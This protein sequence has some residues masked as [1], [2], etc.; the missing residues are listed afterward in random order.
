MYSWRKRLLFYLYDR[1]V[2]VFVDL[3]AEWG[4]C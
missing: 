1:L 4:Q 3:T 2:F